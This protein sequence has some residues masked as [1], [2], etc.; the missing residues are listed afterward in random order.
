MTPPRSFATL[1]LAGFLLVALPLGAAV[2]YA[3]WALDTNADVTRATLRE[4]AL[5]SQLSQQLTRESAE[6]DRAARLMLANNGE[7]ER[8]AY[9]KARE[10]LARTI[11][12]LRALAVAHAAADSLEGLTILEQDLYAILFA[13]PPGHTL[14]PDAAQGSDDFQN[15]VARLSEV[16]GTLAA[17]E[18]H[19]L[20]LTSEAQRT[21]LLMGLVFA[22]ALASAFAVVAIRVLARPAREME[23]IVRRMARGDLDTPARIGGPRDWR[24]LARTLNA[25]R[26]RLKTAEDEKRRFMRH[27]SHEMK[28]PMTA[29]RESAELLGDQTAGPLTPEQ[30]EVT[31]ILMASSRR[32]QRLIEELLSW[33]VAHIR[34][35]ALRLVPVALDTVILQAVSEHRPALIARNIRLETQLAPI[36]CAADAESLRVA[37]DNLLSNAIAHT[38]LQGD[39]AIRATRAGD[40]VHIEVEDSG[41]G[42]AAADIERIFEPFHTRRPRADRTLPG[43]GLGLA[44][45]REH[46]EAHGGRLAVVERDAPGA[47][48]R[49]TLPLTPV[50]PTSAPSIANAPDA[51][52]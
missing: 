24:R 5:T 43:T 19:R 21:R 45:A 17:S 18:S 51:R 38:P 35:R 1:L 50:A 16:L 47:L 12:R 39:I 30:R 52:R 29:I 42:L 31:H 25:L 40:F 11:E 20:R 27:V 32:L 37:I 36:V 4:I 2:L 13:S 49:I 46:V 41:P 22:C 15:G 34:S 48:F 23:D 26:V 3:V 9:T 14:S 44:I 28:T 8:S 6:I 7:R 10:R 33:N